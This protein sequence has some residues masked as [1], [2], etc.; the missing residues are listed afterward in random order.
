MQDNRRV[1]K[2]GGFGSRWLSYLLLFL[3]VVVLLGGLLGR[4]GNGGVDIAVAPT[5]TPI[6]TDEVFDETPES[7]DI[8]LPARQWYALQLGAFES[9][10]AANELAERFRLRGAAGY[11]WQDGRYRALAA[12]YPTKDDA[13]SVRRRLS[14]QH[15]VDTYIY[16]V[17]LPDVRLRL[18]GMR[19]Q[20]DITEAAFKQAHDLVASLQALSVSMDRQ[21]S[22]VE[23]AL[24]TL[25]AIRR[26]TDNIA[27]R[28]RQRFPEPRHGTVTGLLN[29]YDDYAGF[30]AGI[31]PSLSVVELTVLVKRQTFESLRRLKDVYDGLGDT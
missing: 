31:N 24:I 11:V 19:G 2:T 13:Q 22:G 6:P 28:L 7:R 1:Y 4:D 23:E 26:Q 16:I 29:L 9:E 12:L 18:S 30:T 5:Q 10:Q 8:D 21:E 25:G 14:E 15:T 17:E 3:C 27:L 20:L